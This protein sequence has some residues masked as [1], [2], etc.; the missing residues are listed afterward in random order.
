ML[1]G[2]GR[3]LRCARCAF[4]WLAVMP[5]VAPQQ[6]VPAAIAAPDNVPE[7]DEHFGSPAPARRATAAITA[8]TVSLVVLC[9]IGWGAVHWRND[10]MLI[11]P[12]SERAYQAVGLN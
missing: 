12:P 7:D 8:W 4:E 2:T 6:P 9:S 1:A 10:I 5:V 3:R 11:W